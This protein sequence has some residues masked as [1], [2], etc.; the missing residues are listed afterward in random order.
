M[1][2]GRRDIDVTGEQRLAV[3]G[4]ASRQ[5]S[6]SGEDVGQDTAPGGDVE[7]DQH[8]RRKVG[9]QTRDNGR[10]GFDTTS[11]GAEH[12]D[13]MGDARLLSSHLLGP[14]SKDT[15]LPPA[16]SFAPPLGG[17]FVGRPFEGGH[18][19]GILATP[20]GDSDD[21]WVVASAA[22]CRV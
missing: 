15:S 8:G 16:P 9:R 1:V 17:G 6:P 2:I 13:P 11:G 18:R 19:S 4:V 22:V 10:K 14:C 21:R 5:R 7:D 20:A 12:H 3:D